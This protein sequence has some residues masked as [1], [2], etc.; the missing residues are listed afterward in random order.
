MLN[1]LTRRRNAPGRVSRVLA[2]L[3]C[4][5]FVG[6]GTI[7]FVPE[8]EIEVELFPEIRA[9]IDAESISPWHDAPPQEIR[10]DLV[11]LYVLQVQT[12]AGVAQYLLRLVPTAE[13]VESTGTERERRFEIDRDVAEEAMARG[14]TTE[15]GEHSELWV[16]DRP[17]GSL[18][19][20]WLRSESPS[21]PQY[22]VMVD[23]WGPILR[24]PTTLEEQAFAPPKWER[25]ESVTVMPELFSAD[26]VQASHEA[27]QL[28]AAPVASV[29]ATE[30]HRILQQTCRAKFKLI[31][32]LLTTMRSPALRSIMKEVLESPGA[33]AMTLVA[34]NYLL[35][36]KSSFLRWFFTSFGI[37]LDQSHLALPSDDDSEERPVRFDVSSADWK[38]DERPEAHRF[39]FDPS[40]STTQIMLGEVA[41]VRNEQAPLLSAGLVALEGSNP[42]DD[43]VRFKL[44]LLGW[45][46]DRPAG[47]LL[48]NTGDEWRFSGDGASFARDSGGD[49]WL[50]RPEDDA[51]VTKVEGGPWLAGSWVGTSSY[52]ALRKDQNTLDML[53][54]SSSP[55][56]AT[57]HEITTVR[58]EVTALAA[59]SDGRFV[60]VETEAVTVYDLLEE[61]QV[62]RYR[63]VRI[64]SA[65]F[66]SPTRLELETDN[67]D[68]TELPSRHAQLDLGQSLPQPRPADAIAATRAPVVE[69]EWDEQSQQTRLT[70]INGD[71]RIE[72]QVPV[73][74]EQC[75]PAAN[76]RWW[77]LQ[78]WD[79]I[80]RVQSSWLIDPLKRTTAS[81]HSPTPHEK[82]PS[83]Q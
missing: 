10:P 68:G 18:L 63:N 31:F 51:W 53:D 37:R 9:W 76:S 47:R 56:T 79:P 61:R 34:G 25:A 38:Q 27:Q 50:I 45:K 40:I 59:S 83:E 35:R 60:A 52:V 33:G 49:L 2:L 30:R 43:Q 44:A 71:T 75:V 8:T 36:S 19:D 39:R 69:I 20:G 42:Y 72:I 48:S 78:G 22:K 67:P 41:V 81:V 65:G 58:G 28:L 16:A 70:Q 55:V 54:L 29:S 15:F 5:T 1:V 13:R 11:L 64:H 73:R 57:T 74:V 21:T 66:S 7:E 82:Q 46:R 32:A 26:F 80:R 23:T 14:L 62:G 4:F 12:D 77:I 3:A 6:C 17:A 24:D